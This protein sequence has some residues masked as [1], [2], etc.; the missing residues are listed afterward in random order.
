MKTRVTS[1]KSVVRS[2]PPVS[3]FDFVQ[4]IAIRANRNEKSV[5]YRRRTSKFLRAVDETI[6]FLIFLNVFFLRSADIIISRAGVDAA[7]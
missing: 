6:E 1:S 7:G 4:K 5:M 2:V 3:R